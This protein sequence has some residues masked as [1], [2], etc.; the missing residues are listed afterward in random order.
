MELIASPTEQTTAATD[1]IL[2]LMALAALFHLYRIGG[3]QP[4]KRNLWVGLFSLL[5]AAGIIGGFNHGLALPREIYELIWYPLNLIAVLL[6]SLFA[7]ASTHDLLGESA[8]RRAV[9]PMLAVGFAV[10]ASLYLGDGSFLW[11]IL[12]EGVVMLASLGAYLAVAWRGN[13]PGAWW[14][15][16]GLALTIA[17][18]GVQAS[19]LALTLIWPFDHNGLFHLVQMVGLGALVVGLRQGLR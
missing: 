13:L 5:A 10:Y 3:A 17:A 14:M 11:V 19:P 12:Y 9:L 18:A 15:V 6:V 2:G 7:V 16:A 8:G 1:L 4:R